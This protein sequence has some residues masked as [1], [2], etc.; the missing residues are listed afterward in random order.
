MIRTEANIETA[1]A[2]SR[3]AGPS[4]RSIALHGLVAALMFVSP[5]VVFVP[6]AILSSGLRNGR[7]GLWLST[8]AA[9]LLLGM[10]ATAGGSAAAFTPVARM[11]LEVG[12]PSAVGLELI[13]R[14]LPFG[15]VLLASVAASFGGFA[16]VELGMRALAS[17][18]P[19]QA[20]VENFRAASQASVE[21]YRAAGMPA[22]AIS[23]MER[24]SAAIAGTYMPVLLAVVTILMFALSYTM[25]PRLR[26][27]RALAPGML[28]R[29]LAFPEMLLFGF[30][31]GGLAPLASGSLRSLGFGILLVVAFLYL[32]QG[33]AVFR[34]HQVRLRLGL[35][36]SLLAVLT[37]LLLTPYGV[38]PALLFLI[39][40]F[41]PFFDF[42]KLHRKEVPHESD[43]D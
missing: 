9:A 21:T 16:L 4:T 26:S 25:L 6:A 34:F 20:I 12:A 42:R 23:T 27:G 39:G 17:Y 19:Y 40:L 35:L 30:V 31:A 5:L 36:G 41:D 24:V 28:F 37:L 32:L 11:I 7:R 38:S 3:L 13:L 14:G 18:S 8:A 29:N 15:S 1:G 2:D 10:L 33:L 22:E 43:S